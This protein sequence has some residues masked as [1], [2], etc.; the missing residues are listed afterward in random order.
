M[1]FVFRFL[2]YMYHQIG[3]KN[4]SSFFRVLQIQLKKLDGKVQR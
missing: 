1:S 2:I 3:A 4:L